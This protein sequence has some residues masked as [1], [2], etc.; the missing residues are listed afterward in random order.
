VAE[1]E[2]EIKQRRPLAIK[3]DTRH[4]GIMAKVRTNNL[5]CNYRL[6]NCATSSV[7]FGP[8]NFQKIY[9]SVI[10]GCL[11]TSLIASPELDLEEI[12]L[13]EEEPVSRPGK[14]ATWPKLA[15]LEHS[16]NFFYP[17]VFR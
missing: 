14:L 12:L 11:Q 4:S 10:V 1:R 8:G 5:F 13:I 7:F 17:L 2:L 3:R 16:G 6:I 15:F 9:I